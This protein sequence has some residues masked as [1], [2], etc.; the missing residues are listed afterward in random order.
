MSSA[1]ADRYYW[2]SSSQ[3]IQV[4]AEGLN[5]T[6]PFQLERIHEYKKSEIVWV[7]NWVIEYKPVQRRCENFVCFIEQGTTP[8]WDD[9]T[10]EV[11]SL[12]PLRLSQAIVGLTEASAS[13]LMRLGFFQYKPQSWSDLRQD[14]EEA[15][16]QKLI[17]EIEYSNI[18][19]LNARKNLRNIGYPVEACSA[20]TYQ[21]TIQV[22]E[23]VN[24][25]VPTPKETVVKNV[26]ET[27][28]V[29][30]FIQVENPP[31]LPTEK[32]I[33]EIKLLPETNTVS[34]SQLTSFAA[35]RSQVSPDL[36][37]LSLIPTQRNLLDLNTRHI[38]KHEV[39]IES[40]L[41][42]LYVEV[43]PDML[44]GTNQDDQLFVSYQVKY[45]VP[46]WTGMCGMFESW[47]LLGPQTF[48][49]KQNMV[50]VP[51]DLGTLRGK[52][53][54]ELDVSFQRPN[55]VWFNSKPTR[56]GTTNTV[57]LSR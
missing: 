24:R 35:Y 22:E 32:E 53:R 14:I 46:G 18:L 7:D 17:T 47:K 31:L 44:L 45:C 5:Q 49:L 25:P 43:L 13:K 21:C 41:P 51:I 39:K 20:E 19:F 37:A 34:V 54:I 6:Y 8:L 27:K 55:S 1:F 28:Y 12:K 2:A 52:L 29:Q 3:K 23:R 48:A 42:Y 9:Y 10:S 33:F 50:R 56:T 11:G 38:R 36:S 15:K 40:G 4:G 57:N 30:L 26:I 16:S